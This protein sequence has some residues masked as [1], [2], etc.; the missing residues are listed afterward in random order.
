M[1]RARARARGLKS[2]AIIRAL[3]CSCSSSFRVISIKPPPAR[4][5]T[6]P[7]PPPLSLSVS[8]CSSVSL[9]LYVFFVVLSIVQSQRPSRKSR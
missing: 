9:C 6:L 1:T 8:V 7:S 3:F 2:Y 4:L 5:F